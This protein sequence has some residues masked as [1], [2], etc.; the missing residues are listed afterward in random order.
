MGEKEVWESGSGFL[1]NKSE[2]RAIRCKMK[3]RRTD[4]GYRRRTS[5]SHFS[6]QETDWGSQI[7]GERNPPIEGY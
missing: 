5:T 3:K 6:F 4:L 1:L 2:V 7:W